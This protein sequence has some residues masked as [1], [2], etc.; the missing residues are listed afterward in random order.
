MAIKFPC[1]FCGEVEPE[2][3]H[4]LVLIGKET[5]EWGA[6]EQQWWCHVQCLLDRMVSQAR[7]AY[8]AEF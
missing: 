5:A 3:D 6:R 7:D 4:G 1:C 2:A 8:T